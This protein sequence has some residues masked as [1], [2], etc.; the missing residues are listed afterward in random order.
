MFGLRFVIFGV[1]GFQ[2]REFQYFFGL[3]IQVDVR[4]AEVRTRTTVPLNI[5]FDNIFEFQNVNIKRA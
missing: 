5:L 3:T 1:A 2:N 4:H